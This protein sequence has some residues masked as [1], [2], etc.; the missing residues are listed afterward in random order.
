MTATAN[1]PFPM[2]LDRSDVV[3]TIRGFVATEL[4][5]PPEQVLDDLPLKEVAGADSIHLLRVVAQIE[6]RYETEFDDEDVFRVRTINELTS[7]VLRH[8]AGEG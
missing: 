7:L 6:R 1:T 4:R 5:L 3:K 8:Q 2:A